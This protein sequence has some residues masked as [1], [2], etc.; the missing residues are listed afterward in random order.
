MGDLA[1]AA[2][3]RFLAQHISMRVQAL[4]NRRVHSKV[5]FVHTLELRASVL[6]L[7][8]LPRDLMLWCSALLSLSLY[9]DG[10]VPGLRLRKVV[11]DSGLRV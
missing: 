5:V 9:L 2:S 10:E 3:R 8:P 1:F 4:R 11:H 6:L 7:L